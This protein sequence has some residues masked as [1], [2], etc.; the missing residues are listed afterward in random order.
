MAVDFDLPDKVLEDAYNSLK[1]IKE[2]KEGID[3]DDLLLILFIKKKQED[4]EYALIKAFKSLFGENLEE[5]NT[6]KFKDMLMYNG[7]RY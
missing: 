3:F 7:F 5:L 4:K 1:K 2:G 6:E